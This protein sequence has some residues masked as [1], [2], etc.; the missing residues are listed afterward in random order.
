M[1]VGRLE[2][3]CALVAEAQGAQARLV[4][5]Q[6]QEVRLQQGAWRATLRLG[7]RAFAPA[8]QAAAPAIGGRVAEGVEEASIP[9]SVT[10][11]QR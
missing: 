5:H 9:R 4:I 10:A 11:H 1:G 2:G 8:H 6:H 3:L 7:Q